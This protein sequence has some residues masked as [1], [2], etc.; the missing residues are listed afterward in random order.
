VE[1]ALVDRAFTEEGHSD[2]AL[3]AELARE[4]RTDG[5]RDTGPDDRIGAQDSTRGVG[6]VHRAALAVAEP[7]G[8]REELGHHPVDVRPLGH[9]VAVPAVGGR[10]VV[11]LAQGRS[12]A[13]SDR[14]LAERGVHE[15]GDL[16][17]A[18]QVGDL[19]LER[20][21]ERDQ[22]MQ[23]IETDGWRGSRRRVV[24]L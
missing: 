12:D 11:V 1:R 23:L 21:D 4:G 24:A 20:P 15:P 3:A 2:P 17:V 14:L 8:L 16:S 18:V 10:E 22:R 6:D 19:R 7:R 13:C 5:E 9:D